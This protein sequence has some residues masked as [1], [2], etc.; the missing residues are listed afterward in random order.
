M[1]TDIDR[2]RHAEGYG[3]P[4]NP[5]MEGQNKLAS[6]AMLTP[7]AENSEPAELVVVLAF[8]CTNRANRL[9]GGCKAQKQMGGGRVEAV[10][11]EHLMYCKSTCINA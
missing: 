2:P 7:L 5:V 6:K 3:I 9:K 1:A 4:P 11:D 10:R 8:P